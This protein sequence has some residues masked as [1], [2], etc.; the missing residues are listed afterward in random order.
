V[1]A[2]IYF[3][4]LFPSTLLAQAYERKLARRPR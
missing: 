1:V 3:A 2:I 4:L